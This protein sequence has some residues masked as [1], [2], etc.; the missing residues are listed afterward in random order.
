MDR[1]ARR[2]LLQIPEHPQ[3]A[4]H[5]QANLVHLLHGHQPDDC[6]LL[7][8]KSLV[9]EVLALAYV[10]LALPL[11]CTMHGILKQPFSPSLTCDTSY[12]TVRPMEFIVHGPCT[13]SAQRARTSR[14]A[15]ATQPAAC[16]RLENGAWTGPCEF[17]DQNSQGPCTCSPGKGQI[18]VAC[19]HILQQSSTAKGQCQASRHQREGAQS[20]IAMLYGWGKEGL[21]GLSNTK[22]GAKW[23]QRACLHGL[24]RCLGLLGSKKWHSPIFYKIELCER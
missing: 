22:R 15:P 5:G 1:W 7:W 2:V 12:A 13:A 6:A 19:A 21:L 4:T 16:S 11:Q 20:C 14:A 18:P 23:A 24:T 10:C 8:A 3:H 9:A 17:F